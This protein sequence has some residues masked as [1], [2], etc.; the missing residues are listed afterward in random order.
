MLVLLGRERV[1]ERMERM[2]ARGPE[3]SLAERRPG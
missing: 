2:I 1:V 3:L